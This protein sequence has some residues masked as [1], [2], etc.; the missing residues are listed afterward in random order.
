MDYHQEEKEDHMD[1]LDLVTI[2]RMVKE[3]RLLDHLQLL[4]YHQVRMFH[5]VLARS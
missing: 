5:L 1:M 2:D 3:G 4:L